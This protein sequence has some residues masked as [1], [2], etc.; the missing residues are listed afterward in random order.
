ME[1]QACIEQ[2]MQDNLPPEIL[3]RPLPDAAAGV[4]VEHLKNEADRYWL[5]DPR[6]SLELADRIISIGEARLDASQTALGMMAKGDALRFLGRP[7]E[8]WP[9]L[10]R[11]G[12]LFQSA[13]N[14]VGWARTRIGRLDLGVKLKRVDETLADARR[15]SPARAACPR[16]GAAGPR[17]RPWRSRPSGEGPPRPGSLPWR[18]GG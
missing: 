12:T 15:R 11:A 14:E 3:S 6:R 1:I 7:L 2:F 8:A 16:P 4:V 9:L 10:E 18:R 13:G 5:I 17:P